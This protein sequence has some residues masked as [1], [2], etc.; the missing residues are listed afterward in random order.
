MANK[1][2][3]SSAFIQVFHSHAWGNKANAGVNYKRPYSKT[4][5][6]A[7]EYMKKHQ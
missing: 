5:S 2:K 1:G 7:A 3:Q 6:S 4:R